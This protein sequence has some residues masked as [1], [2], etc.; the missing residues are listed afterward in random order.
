MKSRVYEVSLKEANLVG[1]TVG[2][3]SLEGAHDVHGRW[4]LSYYNRFKET[5]QM[6]Q[7]SYGYNNDDEHFEKFFSGLI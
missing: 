6:L 1:K 2:G 5:N 4:A 3:V 7:W